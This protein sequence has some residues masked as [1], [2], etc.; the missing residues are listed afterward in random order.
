MDLCSNR[1]ASNCLNHSITF[2]TNRLK[3]LY[4]DE[5]SVPMSEKT[6]SVSKTKTYCLGTFYHTPPPPAQKKIDMMEI[7]KLCEQNAEFLNAE[8][9]GIGGM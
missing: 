9:G 1:P 5:N 2:E 6:C 8:L 4:N 3:S 7:N